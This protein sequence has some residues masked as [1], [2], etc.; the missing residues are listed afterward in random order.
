MNQPLTV[1]VRRANVQS[2]MELLINGGQTSLHILTMGQAVGLYQDL[3]RAIFS[4]STTPLAT[5]RPN[6]KP[7]DG[8]APIY[9][10]LTTVNTRYLRNGVARGSR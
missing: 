9:Q 2:P 5:E 7:L 8:G 4:G 3:H 10:D 6:G 1:C